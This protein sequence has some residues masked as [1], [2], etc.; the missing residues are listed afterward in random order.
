MIESSLKILQT[1]HQ[2]RVL[3]PLAARKRALKELLK[4]VNEQEEA[5]FSAL[6]TDLGRSRFESYVTEIAIIKEEISCA[7]KNLSAWSM[8]RPVS[9]SLVFQPAQAY[10]KPSPKGVVLIIAP[11]NY[12]FQLSL[13]PL[14]SA[15]A[16]GN[17]A[18]IKPS[19]LSTASAEVLSTIVNDYLDPDC[20]RLFTGEGTLAQALLQLPFDHIF[21]TGNASIASEVMKKAAVN[22]TPLTLELGGKSPCII[23]DHCHLELAAKRIMWA[24]FLNAGQTCIAPDY[25]LIKDHLMGDF[26]NLAKKH[27]QLMYGENS[28]DSE[29]YG[30]II[31]HRHT[32]R[33]IKY[34]SDG[35]LA[36]GGD[37]D[38]DSRF[39]G[40]TLLTK[41]KA[42]SAIMNDEIFGPILPVIDIKSIDEAIKAIN[43]KAQPL[44][45]YIFS[46]HQA[47][48]E[49]IIDHT[50]SG[51]VGINDCISQAAIIGLPFGGIGKSGMGNY[52]GRYGFETFSH[53]RSVYK[54]AN[55][56]DNPLK[57]PP[58]SEQKLKLARAFL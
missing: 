4:G 43:Q 11:W 31:N 22:L 3:L 41:L 5:I 37:Y 28:R 27:L 21:Y 9:S 51:S 40:P 36:Y 45:L 30:R 53:L 46:N 39:I 13:V 6:K 2:E 20:F 29:S 49:H 26:I 15:I 1:S 12:P 24:K 25:V 58:Y 17:C 44:A 7:L 55:I 33:L 47:N 54:K 19:E 50:C 23:D 35:H 14:I 52:R 16:A 38:L 56:L 42:N 8:H 32:E 18:I 57:Y 10:I 34:L 48:I